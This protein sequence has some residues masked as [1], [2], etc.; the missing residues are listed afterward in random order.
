MSILKAIYDAIKNDATVTD[1]L[2]TYD[3][4][5]GNEPA[6][7]T[8]QPPPPDAPAPLVVLVQTGGN[9]IG[10]DRST[11]GGEFEIDVFVWGNRGESEKTINDLAM[12]LWRALDRVNLTVSGYD[13]VYCLAEPP[14]RAPDT[15]GYPGY[16]IRT[17][18]LIRETS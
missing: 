6:I 12:N 16:L 18:A 5:S 1:D 14:E 17:R 13:P 9:L 8:T 15:E 4:G 10:R 3:F 11:R 7:F 2:A